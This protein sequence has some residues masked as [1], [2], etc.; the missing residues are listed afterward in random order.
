MKQA[1][2]QTEIEAVDRFLAVTKSL[3]GAPPEFGPSGFVRRKQSEWAAVWPIA[4]DGLITTGQLR[5]VLRPGGEYRLTISVIFASNCVCRL[6]MVPPAE[7]ESNPVWA[8]RSGLPA[9]VC[10]AHF[11]DWEINRQHVMENGWTLPIREPLPPQVRKI[12]Q[13][14]PWLAQRINLVLTPE[15]RQFDVPQHFA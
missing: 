9:L 10:G 5:F 6:D 4:E 2:R 12:D 14:L 8:A 1:V 15:Q 3:E 7:C 13:A 11:H